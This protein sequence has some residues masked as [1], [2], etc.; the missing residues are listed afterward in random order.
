MCCFDLYINSVPYYRYNKALYLYYV[1]CYKNGHKHIPNNY[2]I[3]LYNRPKYPVAYIILSLYT[4]L[5]TLTA[6]K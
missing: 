4:H 1:V 2:L 3:I 5:E 6:I